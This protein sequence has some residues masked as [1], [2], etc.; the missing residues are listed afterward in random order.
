MLLEVYQLFSTEENIMKLIF[1]NS[2]KQLEWVSV[3]SDFFR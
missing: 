3:D 1:E 2:E